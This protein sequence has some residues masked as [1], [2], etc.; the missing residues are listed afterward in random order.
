M[1]AGTKKKKKFR[2]AINRDWCK[3]C[4]ICIKI[5]PVENL[6]IEEQMVVDAGTCIGCK[7]CELFCPD[8]A[9]EVEEVRG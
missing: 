4:G 8:F 3:G 2:W 5:C 6:S 1:P 7:A 9:I